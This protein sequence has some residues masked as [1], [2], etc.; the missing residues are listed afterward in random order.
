MPGA[1][2]ERL[3]WSSGHASTAT[4]T[5][6]GGARALPARVLERDGFD[7]IDSTE[8][9][10]GVEGANAVLADTGETF[11]DLKAKRLAA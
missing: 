6:R 9:V 3:R 1:R 5:D 2:R 11:A 7:V 8:H 10:D 4:A